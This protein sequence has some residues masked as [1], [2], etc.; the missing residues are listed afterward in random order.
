MH[1][2]KERKTAWEEILKYMYHD[3]YESFKKVIIKNTLILYI[4]LLV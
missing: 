4:V 1:G 2:P 3:P